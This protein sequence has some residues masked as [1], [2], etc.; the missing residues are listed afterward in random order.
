MQGHHYKGGG[1]VEQLLPATTVAAAPSYHGYCCSLLLWLSYG[2]CSD[3]RPW[4]AFVADASTD[5]G[6]CCWILPWLPLLPSAMVAVAAS[7]Y[8]CCSPIKK[9]FV[10]QPLTL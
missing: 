5:H 7:D 10:T 9:T 3:L 1:K 2:F 4:L 6:F 8:G